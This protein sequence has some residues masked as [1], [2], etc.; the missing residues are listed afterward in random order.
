MKTKYPIV[1][2]LLIFTLP[3]FA[4]KTTDLIGLVADSTGNGLL[5]ATV[6][7]LEKTDSTLS[8]FGITETDGR[9]LMKKITPGEYL[10]QVS[11]VGFETLWQ[12]LSIAVGNDKMDV[13]KITLFPASAVLNEV[14]VTADRVPLRMRNDTLEYNAAAFKTQPGA[15]VEELLKKLPGVEVQADGTIKA[16]GETVRNVFV[17]GKEFFGNDP[18]V[19]TKNLPAD[20]VDKVQVYDKKSEM[21]EFSGIE[22]GRDSKTIN[23]SLKEDHKN[24]YFGNATAGGGTDERYQGRFNIN[25]FSSKS[26]LSAIGMA[27]NNNQPGFS[28]N[29]YLQFMGGLGSMMGGGGGGGG[30]SMRLSFDMGDT[31]VPLEGGRTD[32]ILSTA[33]AGLNFNRDFGKKTEFQSSYFLSKIRNDIVQSVERQNLLGDASFL[34]TED[35]DQISKSFNH[36]I[37]LSLKHEI[38]SFQNF[39]L[40]SNLA[41]SD[42]K[43]SSDGTSHSFGFGGQLENENLR[44]YYS[45]GQR[46]SLT[47]S[48]TYR[49]RF[50]KKGRAFVADGSLYFGDNTQDGH[51]VS[52]TNFYQTDTARVFL[53]QRQR[54]SDDAMS[55][56]LNVSYTEPIGKAK[57][58]ELNASRQNYTNE[59]GK[60]F[61]DNGPG[62]EVLNGSLSNHYN[63]G[64]TYDR[65]GLNLMINRKK[66]NLTTGSALQRSS[67]EGQQ[68]G[69]STPLERSF[70]RLLPSLF[71]NYEA[72]I[73]KDFSVEYMTNLREPSPEQLQPLVD[74]SDPLN[75]YIG[76]PS[77]QPEYAHNLSAHFMRFDQF[78]F[79]SFFA[80]LEAEFVKDRITNTSSVDSLLRRTV[81]PINVKNDRSLRGY[82]DFST[83]LRPL[84]TTVR[85]GLNSSWNRGI[86]FVN[87]LQNSTDRFSNGVDLSFSNRK[88]E[89]FDAT[90]GARLSHN[91]TTYSEAESLNQT[92][93][94]RR[95]YAEAVV[96]PNKKWE[97]GSKFRYS[98]Y[99][100]ENFGGEQVVPLWEASVSRYLLENNRGK[101]TLSAFDI[102]NKNIGVRRNSEL[103]YVEQQRI[104]TLQRYVMLTFAYSIRGFGKEGG[105]TI[106]IRGP[107]D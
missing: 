36:R 32:G 5:A 94:N 102:L 39:S 11:Y 44:D 75:L 60:D 86:L 76:N 40:R 83:P 15:V 29:D 24:G 10:L 50:G 68:R 74:N 82:V 3:I 73:G 107:E 106:D 103:N 55:Y 98:V 13:G 65:T 9:F 85:F 37:N 2:L 59:T 38:D 90:I 61:Y 100:N 70:T 80:N 35:E 53:D 48:A 67:L 97:F 20:A 56:G 8:A 47:N 33:A 31:G 46:F 6:V 28:F 43:Y 81:S 54:T 27:N 19:A 25:R 45:T 63:R 64:Y 77:L 93:L 16:Q 17:D 49:R 26:Q 14:E 89:H 99:S 34:S 66:W 91:R 52:A 1:L 78:T 104:N 71:F 18:Q 92:Y 105:I 87:E 79:T 12:P 4:Q 69:E 72:G 95:Y 101:L 62:G 21:A 51:L 84:K 41:L 58:L 22:D 30:R 88:K 7:L 23:L 96:Y 42:A 57:Y